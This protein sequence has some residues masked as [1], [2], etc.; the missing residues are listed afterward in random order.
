[1]RE[2]LMNVSDSNDAIGLRI[3]ANPNRLTPQEWYNQQPGIIKG[4]PK[5]IKINGYDAIQDGQSV[6]INAINVDTNVG[7]NNVY[8][9]IYL[10]SYNDNANE[11]T[12]NIVKLFLKDSWVFN[13]NIN[14]SDK[15]D[16]LRRDLKRVK[17]IVAINAVLKNYY[18]THDNTYPELISGTYL[19]GRTYS[20]WPSWSSALGNA[21][22]RS[23]PTDPVNKFVGCESPYDPITCWDNSPTTNVPFKGCE[24]GSRVY[25]YEQ[26]NTATGPAYKLKANFENK[27]VKWQGGLIFDIAAGDSCDSYI[28]NTA[29]ASDAT[30]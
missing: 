23:L 20:T 1:M 2:Y 29:V 24:D 16:S 5:P 26:Y 19:P 27:S 25:G 22:G 10:L 3:Y 14:A 18:D 17:D 7:P 9:N 8:T 30:Q 21:V 13:V 11:S 15:V 12:Q 4:A 6:Y 28:Y